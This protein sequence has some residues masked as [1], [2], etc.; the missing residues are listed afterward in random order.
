MVVVVN[1]QGGRHAFVYWLCA[2]ILAANAIYIA[3]DVLDN[4]AELG[5]SEKGISI[6]KA[7]DFTKLQLGVAELGSFLYYEG[8]WLFA[9]RYFKISE[10]VAKIRTK[11]LCAA[12]QAW[13]FFAVMTVL[14]AINYGY[15]MVVVSQ[16]ING[17]LYITNIWFP[18]FLLNFSAILLLVAVIRVW[19]IL[20]ADNMVTCNEKYMALHSSLLPVLAAAL[21]I[22][23][24][25][26][27]AENQTID[28]WI[29]FVTFLVYVLIDLAV[30]I[31]I[32]VILAKISYNCKY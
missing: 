5:H 11:A 19:R 27:Y 10:S 15:G 6:E 17:S 29:S 14:N 22:N 28:S 18:V 2:L 26:Y 25:I 1:Y 20:R 4:W 23:Y 32:A 30:S 9:W 24:L 16:K 13:V 12:W 31:G 7:E 8:H 3:C 21:M